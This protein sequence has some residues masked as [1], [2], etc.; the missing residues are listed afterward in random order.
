MTQDLRL[1]PSSYYLPTG[2]YT[3]PNLAILSVKGSFVKLVV[4]GVQEN[5]E[6]QIPDSRKQQ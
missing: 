3:H 1:G 5:I 6:K 4:C 2:T